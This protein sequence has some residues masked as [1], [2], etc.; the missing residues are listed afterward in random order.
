MPHVKRDDVRMTRERKAF[1]RAL[2]ALRLKCGLSQEDLAFAS[3]YH[4]VY[5]SILET[6][7]SSASLHAILGLARGL[8]TSASVLMRRTADQLKKRRP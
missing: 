2:R 6:G 8:E 3:G 7:R 4:P 1:G 5:I